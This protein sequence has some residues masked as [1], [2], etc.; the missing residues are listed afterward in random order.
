MKKASILA[1]FSFMILVMTS[2]LFANCGDDDDGVI[3]RPDY[4]S[5]NYKLAIS[6]DLLRFYNITATYV[7][8]SGEEK[9]ENVDTE[10]WNRKD[11]LDGKYNTSFR[12]DVIAIA[13]QPLPKLSNEIDAYDFKCE[14]SAE[15]YTKATSAK[16]EA[17]ITFDKTVKKENL[18]VF[19]QENDT[20]SLVNYKKSN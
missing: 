20:I 6:S 12:L 15:Y 7:N 5:I 9:T 17:R 11:K 8:V 19:L 2:L 14:F 4:T 13:R 18:A 16:R 1:I 3:E 10:S